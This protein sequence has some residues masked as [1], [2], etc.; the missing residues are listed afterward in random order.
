MHQ[1]FLFKWSNNWH[2]KKK[3]YHISVPWCMQTIYRRNTSLALVCNNI[4]PLHTQ[5]CK[6]QILKFIEHA[7][8]HLVGGGSFPPPQKGWEKEEKEKKK[9]REKE[10]ERERERDDVEVSSMQVN[11]NTFFIIVGVYVTF[12]NNDGHPI[13]MNSLTKETLPNT[14]HLQTFT[15]KRC[16]SS[17]M[18]HMRLPCPLP[19]LTKFLDETL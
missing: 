18:L 12:I 7:E 19:P 1:G 15:C 8:F 10:R 13:K 3:K 16:Y 17:Y 5:R 9:E 2:T 11:H 14:A 4:A 6:V